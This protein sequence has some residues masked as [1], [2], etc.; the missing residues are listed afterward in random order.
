MSLLQEKVKTLID[1]ALSTRDDLFLIH[2]SVDHNNAIKIL[3][4]GDHGVGID[5]CV[6]ISRKVEQSL[7]REEEDFSLEVASYGISEPLLTERQYIKNIGRTLW[8]KTNDDI[9][10]EGTLKAIE[11]QCLSLEVTSREPKPVGKGKITVTRLHSIALSEI[12]Q[13]KVIIKF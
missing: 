4:D 8:V 1:S 5:D 9:E 2:F 12:K 7:D 6:D 3:I 13:A 11:Q 10:R